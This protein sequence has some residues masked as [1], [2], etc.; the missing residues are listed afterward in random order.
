MSLPF[1]LR[2]L[3]AIPIRSGGTLDTSFKWTYA[4]AIGLEDIAGNYLAMW[5]QVETNKKVGFVFADG[6]GGGRVDR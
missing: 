1:Q 3:A 4:Y 6:P 5:D 2:S